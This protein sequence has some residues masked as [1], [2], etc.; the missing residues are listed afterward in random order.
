MHQSRSIIQ[1]IS[2]HKNVEP[3]IVKAVKAALQRFDYKVFLH[4]PYFLDIALM[5]Y[6]LLYLLE[7]ML[8]A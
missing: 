5:D 3:L 6:H 1:I 7:I 4:A 2:A 8:V